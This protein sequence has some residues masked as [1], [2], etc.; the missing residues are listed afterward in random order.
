MKS[1]PKRIC[2]ICVEIFAFG[3][4]GGF[5]KATRTIGAEL[6]KRGYEVFAVV[7]RRLDQRA[8][9]N[10]DGITVLSYKPGDVL[11][12]G[13][14]YKK[15]NADIYHS[16]EPSVG[17]YLAKKHVPGARHIATVRYPRDAHDWYLD[18]LYPSKNK[19]Q[20]IKNYLYESNFIVR[21]SVRKLDGVYAPAQYMLSKIKRIYGL[22]EEP[23]FLPTPVMVPE[24]CTKS[25]TPQVLMM[26]RLDPRK[27]PEIFL[28]L[29]DKF[30]EVT[31]HIAG[32]SRVPEYEHQLKE[33]YHQPNIV[34]HGFVDQFRDALHHDLM[35][36]SWI[37]LNC[38]ILEGLPNAYLEAAAHQMAILSY[39]N[40]DD[41]ASR[42]GF[43]AA[44]DNFEEGLNTLLK[45]DNWK[46]QGMKGHT[47]VKK[48]FS[49]D[50][51]MD[52]HEK[53]YHSFFP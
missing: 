8:E 23:V 11:S 17:T 12:S 29:A 16:C 30:P 35:E 43:H 31:F 9:E 45:N 52:Q 36:K 1:K 49:L 47:H 41:F 15:I 25:A 20:V 14:L 5:G 38:A 44:T 40:P 28:S 37:L 3:K 34:F 48:T 7:P 10:L 39:V 6:V 50:I 21:H 13:A 24:S 2:L 53:I 4:Y 33:K 27:R 26:S 42:F 32:M 46:S 22:K 51:A 18:F 19:W